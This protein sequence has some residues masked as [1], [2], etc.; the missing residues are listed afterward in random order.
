M[1]SRAG[2]MEWG[3]V[4]VSWSEVT[5]KG[6]ANCP[7]WS[8]FTNKRTNN[9]ADSLS[10]RRCQLVVKLKAIKCYEGLL[11][12][13]SSST[14]GLL[15]IAVTALFVTLLLGLQEVERCRHSP[16]N[17]NPVRDKPLSRTQRSWTSTPWRW[18]TKQ[19]R[20]TLLLSDTLRL[21]CLLNGV[22]NRSGGLFYPLTLLWF[23]SKRSTE[24]V[25][26]NYSTFRQFYDL[27]RHAKHR[28]G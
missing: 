18:Y 26:K 4:Q 3:H 19:V 21:S 17:P 6:Y 14:S 20:R 1:R 8:V 12:Y 2:V 24:Q 9:S 28:T 16:W 22:P 5:C 15:L 25:K 7:G 11:C 27:A 13:L 23:N 10:Q